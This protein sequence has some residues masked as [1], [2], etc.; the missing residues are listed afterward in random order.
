M[1]Q[2]HSINV[3]MVRINMRRGNSVTASKLGGFSE[4]LHQ[5]DVTER[6]QRQGRH[7]TQTEVRPDPRLKNN[8]KKDEITSEI[9]WM[10]SIRVSVTIIR[11]QSHWGRYI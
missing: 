10:P 7:D 9:K 1:S 4:R 8:R 11:C 6:Q 5:A 3:P 2:S